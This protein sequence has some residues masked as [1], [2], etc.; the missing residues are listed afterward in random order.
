M[1]K[2]WFAVVRVDI[3]CLDGVLRHD[4]RRDGGLSYR[5]VFVV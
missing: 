2:K 3:R 4:A 1:I 5:A